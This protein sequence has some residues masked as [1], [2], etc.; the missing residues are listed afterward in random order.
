M[1]KDET[2]PLLADSFVTKED[3]QIIFG[4][5]DLNY[6][7]GNSM[8]QPPSGKYKEN[9]DKV[10]NS[11]GRFLIDICKTFHCY[12]LNNLTF[13]GKSF[14]D[15]FTFYK[16][17]RKSQND[18]QW[19]IQMHYIILKVLP[20]DH[21][22]VVASCNFPSRDKDV[23]SIA[24]SDLLTTVSEP[25]IKRTPKTFIMCIAGMY[26][27]TESIIIQTGNYSI[28]KLMLV[29]K[30]G[31][32]LSPYL[33]L[34]YINDI[35][36]YVYSMCPS[37]RDLLD[38][39]HL[40]IHADDANI[41]TSSRE[42]M[43]LKIKS[44]LSYCTLNKIQ[45]QLSKCKFIVING[46]DDDKKDFITDMGPSSSVSQLIIL[47]S[48]LTYTGIL[49]DDLDAHLKDKIKNIIKYFNFIRSNRTALIS[50][51]LKVLSSCVLSTIL[52]NCETFG[53]M[54]P[55]G[56]EKPYHKLIRSALNVR[57]NTPSELILIE[58]GL[59]PLKALVAKRQL[60]F[61]RKFKIS[62]RNN[63][64][65]QSVFNELLLVENR[66]T[67]LNHYVSLD[68]KYVES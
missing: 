36:D 5:G 16:S 2:F 66:T 46:S 62:I 53:H 26:K 60:K 8:R 12:P 14:D 35:F 41:L 20:S 27:S 44:V 24:A 67:Y 49:K 15:K 6:R 64:I 21:F 29:I 37:N 55:D 39:L 11:H 45:L 4:G 42:S 63:S 43:V 52:Y 54:L 57:H 31:L 38:K 33:F 22:P 51:K 47:G 23:K 19:E 56:I 34:F 1:F 30:Q 59:L 10:V 50:I 32:P 58:S 48:P 65:R 17:N 9:P 7:I 40:L 61:F 25:C 28:Y 68:E 18:M 13:N 3:N